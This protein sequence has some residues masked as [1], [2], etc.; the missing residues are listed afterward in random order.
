M[1]SCLCCPTVLFD[2]GGVCCFAATSKLRPVFRGG[3]VK[4]YSRYKERFKV[5][6]T[7]LIKHFRP[8]HR[9]KRWAKTSKQLRNLRLHECQGMVAF[10]VVQLQAL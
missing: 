7:G 5:T 8:G 3:K 4:A 6:G 1:A 2:Q 10:G 9:H